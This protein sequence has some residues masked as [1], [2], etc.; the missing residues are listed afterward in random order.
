MNAPITIVAPAKLTVSLRVVGV[1]DDGYHLIDAVMTT[2]ELHDEISLTPTDSDTELSFSGPF[3]AGIPTDSTN[4]V[5]RALRMAG[6]SARVKV[7]KNIPHGGGLGGG[8]ADAAAVLR[9]A[10]FDD[11]V[12]ASRLGADIPFCIVGGRAR[13]RGIGESIEPMP[14]EPAT[15]TLVIPPLSVS[16]P[17]VYKKWDELGGPRCE[18][19]TNPNDLEDAALAV[20]PALRHWRDRI[21][22]ASGTDPVL[23]GSGATWFLEGRHEGL[24]LRLPE[25]TVVET[26]GY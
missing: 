15:Y 8:S 11:L 10:G 4:L 26:T 6:R 20:E 22:D 9:W 14:S 3:A 21:R 2:L 17:A 19:E 7:V 18:R 25:A 5:A 16:T 24:A 12:T 23:A 13:V 1:R